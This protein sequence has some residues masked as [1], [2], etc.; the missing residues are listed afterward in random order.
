MA[1]M[2]Q[3]A[4]REALAEAEDRLDAVV[5]ASAAAEL[6]RLGDDLFS[7]LRLLNAEPSLRRALA[8]ASVPASA[9]SGL[10]VAKKTNNRAKSKK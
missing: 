8:D 3:P 2:L 9:R 1:L 7:V 6:Q 4:S 10:A 5:D